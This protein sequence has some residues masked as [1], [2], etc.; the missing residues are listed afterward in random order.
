VTGGADYVFE[1]LVRTYSAAL[2]D[3]SATVPGP[4][5]TK[6]SPSGRFSMPFHL[7]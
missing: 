5:L 7:R 6:K 3:G 2:S 4:L 1:N